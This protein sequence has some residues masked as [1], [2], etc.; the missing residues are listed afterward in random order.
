MQRP[1]WLA[2]FALVIG[3]LY[4]LVNTNP[5]LTWR[6]TTGPWGGRVN[7]IVVDP[8]DAQVRYLGTSGGV[9]KSTNFGRVWVHLEH[10]PLR[11]QPI[12]GLAVDPSDP[13][14]I[15]AGT[16]DGLMQSRDA[17][18][19]W[20]LTNSGLAP[21]AVTCIVVHPL[22]PSI[23]YLAIGG[24]VYRSRDRAKS[25]VLA[26]GGLSVV[27]VHSIAPHPL[28]P[29]LVYAGT[30]CGV[31]VSADGGALWHAANTGLPD[32]TDVFAIAIAPRARQN[33]F[34]ATEYGVYLATDGGASWRPASQAAMKASCSVLAVDPGQ[35]GVLYSN[36]GLDKAWRSTDGGRTWA[37]LGTPSQL[38]AIV[39]LAVD[40]HNSLAIAM[41]STSG[42]H[43]S[44]DGGTTWASSNEGLSASEVALLVDVASTHGGLYAVG[45]AGFF[46]TMDAGATWRPISTDFETAHMSLL[47]TDLAD[48]QVLYSIVDSRQLYRSGDD[49]DTWQPMRGQLPQECRP[50]CLVAYRRAGT[51]LTA[52]LLFAG[53]EACGVVGSSDGGD[54]WDALNAGLGDRHIGAMSLSQADRPL[55]YLGAG[56]NVYA[57]EVDEHSGHQAE[58]RRLNPRPL[59][60]SVTS[61]L[62]QD[63]GRALYVA[64]EFGGVYRASL[65]A[66][67]WGFV[68]RKVVPG[69]VP[70]TR[71]EMVARDGSRP[72]LCA[73]TGSGLYCSANDGRTWRLASLP[74]AGT[75]ALCMVSDDR[76]VGFAYVGTSN[77]GVWRCEVPASPVGTSW[78]VALIAAGTIALLVWTIMTRR[79]SHLWTALGRRPAHAVQDW[80]ACD[81]LIS[82]VLAT[83]S[84]VMAKDVQTIPEA[85][86]DVALRH[87]VELHRELGLRYDEDAQAL[88]TVNHLE[89]E[90]FE[91]NWR[92]LL[93]RLGNMATAAPI[94]A[95]IAE[96]LCQLLGF[97]PIEGR[98]FRSLY[99]YVLRAP[100]LQLSIPHSFPVVFVLD[101]ELG[102]EKV[103][104]IRDLMSVL[105]VTSFFA[106]VVVADSDSERREHKRT[107]ARQVRGSGEDLIV[108]DYRDLRDLFMSSD[109]ERRFM[110][111]VLAQVD[112]TVVSPYVLSGPV[113]DRMFYGREYELKT[114]MRAIRDR[115]Y[116]I[117]GGRKIGKTSLL[118][119]VNRLIG[120]TSGYCSYHL[121]CQPVTS[122]E[123]F[124]ASLGATCQLPNTVPSLDSM[125]R[126]I[127][128]LRLR[129]HG[130]V[131]VLLLDEVDNL[132]AFD[133]LRQARLFG[134]FRA[135][136]QEGLCRFV[137]CGERQLH[138][139][140][141]DP[142][143]PM[144]N[145]TSVLPLTYLSSRAA[146]RMVEE[147]MA[148]LGITFES[149]VEIPQS[150]VE[151]SS[152]HP[153]L[154]QFI[155]QVLIETISERGDRVIRSGDLA[156][157][158]A[159]TRFREFFL[160]VTWGSATP[161]EKLI[162]LLMVDRTGFTAE[163]VRHALVG[164]GKTIR[165]GE[166][167]RALDELVLFSVLKREDMRYSFAAVS[168]PIVAREAKVTE[169]L[170]ETWLEELV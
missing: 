126:T 128:Q 138:A 129:H 156:Q 79:I 15:Y 86:R 75:T 121:D 130:C 99:G 57:L 25:W 146:Q 47:T 83:K 11:R 117:V 142:H 108:L 20:A 21:G 124:F 38:G 157:V 22:H 123:D 53:L 109:V 155:C 40:P 81:R 61:I 9:F 70:V 80:E 39:T 159:S 114:I 113:M 19:T 42:Y 29:F 65:R 125:R 135:L 4:C 164:R 93:D 28:D 147:P 163:D 31:Y 137:F 97:A 7:A 41:G 33:L 150:I 17:G 5:A 106:L 100:A 27:A 45:S 77:H 154:V 165:S 2:V 32:S 58:W 132:L 143:S 139:A 92:S 149:P 52:T 30:D 3:I 116:S 13:A 89:L 95:R 148:S 120:Q 162:T 104:D 136:S 166:L 60:G 37:T 85:S 26:S 141:H 122:Y 36:P 161:L 168:F 56:E 55:L 169:S 152:C 87:Y 63:A 102:E 98:V 1:V 43:F 46:H 23:L 144:F 131:I 14:R 115:S 101:R 91:S 112:L 119:K 10:G 73:L 110:E 88:E 71:L 160:E 35:P 51:P 118:A 170:V 24:Q 72:I 151:L 44:L 84:R 62:A 12:Q 59:N 140:L 134:L 16:S 103:R 50:S 64:T 68:A 133:I 153:N 94:A 76:E 54:H 145:F 158:R 96:Q 6:P 127:M 18:S 69:Q 74:G 167:E 111:L 105:S 67:K 34:L 8:L 82:G 107:L 90:H 49:G 48:A 66:D 78:L